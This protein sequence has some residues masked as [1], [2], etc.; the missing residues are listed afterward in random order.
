MWPIIGNAL[1]D[2]LGMPNT[3]TCLGSL[4]VAQHLNILGELCAVEKLTA[5]WTFGQDTL[6]VRL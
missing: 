4:S 5:M 6:I 2:K 1:H 3:K